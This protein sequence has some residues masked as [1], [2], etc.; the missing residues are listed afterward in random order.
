MDFISTFRVSVKLRREFGVTLH[1]RLASPPPW[2]WSLCGASAVTVT[3]R[4]AFTP[5]FVVGVAH[6]VGSDKCVMTRSHHWRSTQSGLTAPNT[7][8][9]LGAP[10][11]PGLTVCRRGAE[12]GTG[13]RGG[14]PTS[15]HHV[16]A[17]AWLL[18]PCHRPAGLRQEGHC[19]AVP[20]YCHVTT[21]VR[22]TGP[23]AQRRLY[24]DALQIFNIF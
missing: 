24:N 4:P 15:Q 12:A 8:C 10:C 16:P 6:S 9:S 23:G 7:V 21:A 2:A 11:A 22:L 3:Q 1:P 20:S 13:E 19:L 17:A 14:G 5:G 18:F